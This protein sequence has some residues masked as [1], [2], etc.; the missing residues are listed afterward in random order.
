MSLRIAVIAWLLLGPVALACSDDGATPADVGDTGASDRA[1]DV[2]LA[3]YDGA[4]VPAFDATALGAYLSVWGTGP[5]DVVTVGGQPGAGAAMAWDGTSW[6]SLAVPDGPMLFWVHGSGGELWMVGEAGR[7][8]RRTAGGDWEETTTGVDVDLWGVYCVTST[9]V[10]A[11]GGNA[12]DRDGEPALLHWDGERW[13]AGALPALDRSAPALFKVWGTSADNVYAVGS[14][15]LLLHWDGSGWH[16]ELAG[17]TE[18]LISLWGTGPDDIAITGGRAN[19]VLVRWD[20]Q[21]WT[22]E[23]L[24][25]LPGLNGVW[26]DAAGTTHLVGERGTAVRVPAGRFDFEREVTGTT[27]TVHGVWGVHGGPRFAVGGSLMARPPFVG[28]VLVDP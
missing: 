1:S 15:G 19:G 2:P 17:T 11:V 13:E 16:Q 26:V 18:D 10:W 5:S 23:T 28:L 24:V 25:G 8:L 21:S 7:A 22:S 9:D 6:S 14:R 27:L 3:E 20:G 4:W 12:R